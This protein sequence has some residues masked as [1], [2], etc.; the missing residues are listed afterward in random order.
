M[1]VKE[2]TG[3]VFFNPLFAICKYSYNEKVITFCVIYTL[4]MSENVVIACVIAI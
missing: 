1:S 2:N 4:Q 3:N